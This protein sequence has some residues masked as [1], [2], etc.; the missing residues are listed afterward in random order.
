MKYIYSLFVLF[1]LSLSAA[2]QDFI[3]YPHEVT[4]VETGQVVKLGTRRALDYAI[5]HSDPEGSVIECNGKLE[6]VSLGIGENY[7]DKEVV[8]AD[9]IRVDLGVTN[10][11]NH[12]RGCVDDPSGNI[13]P[14]IRTKRS[15]PTRC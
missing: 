7:R 15:C 6:G 11:E 14:C 10:F 8:R 4:V 2:A 12:L 5:E 3:C 1:L 9:P 13:V